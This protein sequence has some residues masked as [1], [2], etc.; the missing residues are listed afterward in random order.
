ML[1]ESGA[2]PKP[3]EVYNDISGTIVSL[4]ILGAAQ[5]ALFPRWQDSGSVPRA[6]LC[7]QYADDNRC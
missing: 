1:Q 6:Q 4:E 5:K 3:I 2:Q 7:S